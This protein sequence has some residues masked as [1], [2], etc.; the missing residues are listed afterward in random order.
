MMDAKFI[1][2]FIG[3][4]TDVYQVG[5]DTAWEGFELKSVRD[6]IVVL[7]SPNGWVYHYLDIE[8]ICAISSYEEI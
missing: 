1:E 4:T 6:G 7:V 2:K 8:L 5:M 3:R